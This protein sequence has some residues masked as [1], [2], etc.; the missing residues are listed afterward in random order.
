MKSNM[1]L[2]FCCILNK[3]EYFMFMFLNSID[4]KYF[5]L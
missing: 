3:F 4:G 1:N 5:K 2:I